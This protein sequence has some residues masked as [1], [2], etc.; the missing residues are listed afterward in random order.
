MLE[1]K[2]GAGRE[3]AAIAAVDEAAHVICRKSLIL[4]RSEM[5]VP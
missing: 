4:Q 1:V 3:G 2:A 5:E